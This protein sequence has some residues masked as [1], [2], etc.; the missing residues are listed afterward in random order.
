MQKRTVFI[1]GGGGMVGA[2]SA[3][4]LAVKEI[5]SDIALIDIDQQLVRG[6]A[7]DISHATAY[8]KSVSVR[9]GDYSEIKEDDIVVIT[10]G[11]SQQPG[12][13]RMDLLATNAKITE[14]VARSAMEQG[15]PIFILVV[16]N[17][18]DVLT[19][20]ALKTSG[21][22]KE[23]V[24]GTGTT[25]DTA[26]LKVSLANRLH[27]SQ[28]E[29][30]AYVMGEHGDSSF[31]A[32]S[33]ATIGGLPLADFPGFRHH[34]FETIKHDIRNA[35]YEI[36]AAKKSTYYGIGHVV[37][38]IVEALLHDAASIYPVCSLTEGE[39]GLHG[40]VLGL[41]SL[42]SARGVRILDHYPLTENEHKQLQ[43]SAKVIRGA[44]EKV[45]QTI[46]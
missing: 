5:A 23:R 17:P 33:G 41:P 38:K 28:K 16:A 6:Q 37:A 4:V 3:Q 40:V 2:S 8:T 20:I 12:Q 10:S 18:V 24:F 39:Y 14:Q 13:T 46:V 45:P 29:V 19:H 9:V 36:I 27:V 31:P 1:V 26:R 7:M 30:Q 21:L 22:P 44:L 34:E 11:V 42:V 35:V 25:L 32:L 15:K 43:D